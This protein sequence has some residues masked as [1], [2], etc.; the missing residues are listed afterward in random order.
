[1][2]TVTAR[3]VYNRKV[4]TTCPNRLRDLSLF[5]LL[6]GAFQLLHDSDLLHRFD[7]DDLDVLGKGG[8]GS[9]KG[10]NDRGTGKGKSKHATTEAR[11]Q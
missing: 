11:N 2:Q 8:K 6:S 7:G 5:R 10:G 9:G 4:K 1:M 3:R